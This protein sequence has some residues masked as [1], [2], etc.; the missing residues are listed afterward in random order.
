M[1]EYIVCTTEGYTSGSDSNVDVENCQILGTIKALSE[2]DAIEKLFA[3]NLW[4]MK[5]GFSIDNA[6]AYALLTSSI[7]ADLKTIIDYLW[8]D[9]Q[10]HFQEN[11]YPQNHIFNVLKRLKSHL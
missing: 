4:I 6:F 2:N 8:T 11:Q 3:Q 10:R 5:A 9:E 1:N 7:M